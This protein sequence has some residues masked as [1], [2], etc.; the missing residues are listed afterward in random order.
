M[1]RQEIQ[2]RF[3]EFAEQYSHL[4]LYSRLAQGLS[5]DDATAELLSAAGPGQRR[6]VM[7]LAAFHHL[8]LAEPSLP[9]AQFFPTVAGDA[10]RQGDPWPDVRA[11]AL[12]NADRLQ[13]V[14]ATHTV[15]TNEVNRS[16]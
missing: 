2:T 15:Q 3:R 7:W 1:A 10:V 16:V 4:P 12:A 6:P 11:A 13:Q 8:V 5:Q 14:M 9:A